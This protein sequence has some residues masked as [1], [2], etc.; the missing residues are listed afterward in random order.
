MNGLETYRKIV[1]LCPGQRAI[2]A[3]GYSETEEVRETQRLG[4]GQYVKKPYTMVTI[5]Q[6]VRAELDR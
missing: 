1:S 3:S 6:A 4:A 2:I 5:G